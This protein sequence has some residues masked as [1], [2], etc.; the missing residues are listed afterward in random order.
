MIYIRSI[1]SSNLSLDFY[2]GAELSTLDFV[3]I[4]IKL[5][6]TTQFD[7]EVDQCILIRFNLSYRL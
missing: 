1:S 2:G 3:R 7:Y 6:S 4:S 5:E